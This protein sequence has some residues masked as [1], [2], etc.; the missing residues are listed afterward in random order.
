MPGPANA[1][2]VGGLDLDYDDQGTGGPP[3]LLLHG[4]TGARSD[5]ADVVADLAGTRRVI[6]YSQRGHGAS[7]NTGSR[8]S[9][10]FD[11]LVADLAG[12]LDA[13]A[14]DAVHLLGHSMGGVVAQRFV[15]E[16]PERVRSLLLMD[17][18][19]EPA[20]VLP[21]EFIEPLAEQGRAS[22]MAAVYESIAPLFAAALAPV[23]AGDPE[24]ARRLAAR[25]PE[26]FAQLDPEAFVAFAAEL[27]AYPPLRSRLGEIACPTTVLVGELDAGLRAA[28]VVMAEAIP[29]AHLVVIPGAGHSPQD[30]RPREWLDA[31]SSHLAW[32]E[33]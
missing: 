22:G 33:A 28:A 3:L 19:P 6:A 20:G 21:L 2:R 1:L 8:A 7:T 11:A 5:W 30:D 14:V 12:V 29:G 26:K 32:A 24:R 16:H 13:L 18:A 9:Y 31:V 17:T 23:E 25:G 10:T 4:Y 15:L 27:N